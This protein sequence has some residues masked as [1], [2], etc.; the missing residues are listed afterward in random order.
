MT[1]ATSASEN[2]GVF[3]EIYFFG[4]TKK[5]GS[6][7]QFAAVIEGESLGFE[8]GDKDGEGFPMANGGRIWKRTPEGD[9]EV[10]AKIYPLSVDVTDAN[11][12][13]QYFEGGTY[14]ASAPI[15]QSNSHNRDLFR[16]AVLFTDD[17]AATTAGGA[18]AANYAARRMSA[19]DLRFVSYKESYDG[20]LAAEV[21]FKG[22]AFGKDGSSLVTRESVTSQDGVGLSALAAYS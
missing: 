6:E 20:Q 17:P 2:D 1:A 10:S 5:G 7:V 12:M 8:Q 18:T 4:V 9:I 21:K 11:D 15:S 13:S 3:Q 16:V 14:D 19:K 22:P